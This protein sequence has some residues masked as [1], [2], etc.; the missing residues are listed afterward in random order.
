VAVFVVASAQ[1]GAQR[2]ALE[3][4][5]NGLVAVVRVVNTSSQSVEVLL[6]QGDRVHVSGPFGQGT[7]TVTIPVARRFDWASDPAVT[8][9][10]TG[11]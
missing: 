4:D 10:I 1:D 11:R 8:V 9:S 6:R 3:T 5:A 2:L 7:Q